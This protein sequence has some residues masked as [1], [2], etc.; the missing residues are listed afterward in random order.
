MTQ[1]GKKS[2]IRF[3]LIIFIGLTVFCLGQ[4]SW[5]II[6]TVSESSKHAEL[7]KSLYRATSGMDGIPETILKQIEDDKQGRIIMFV[8]ESS[9]FVLVILSGAFLIY[10][11]LRQSEALQRQQR[12]F[13]HAV[14]HEFRTPIT[15][16]KL[17]LETLESGNISSDKTRDI[18]PKM[19]DD[20]N[21]LETLID[22]VLQAGHFSRADYVLNL[23]ETDF[24]ED[25]REYIHSMESYITRFGGRIQTDIS[26]NIRV[27][28]DYNSFGRAINALIDNALKYSSK[29]GARISVSL[30]V[31][32]SRAVLKVSDSGNGIEPQELAKIFNRFYRVGDEN[33]R[34]VNG[35]GLGLFLVREIVEAHQGTIMA[36]SPGKNRGATFTI[37]LPLAGV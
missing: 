21:R 1:T 15:S 10:R 8:S 25:M 22:N 16:L 2:P 13:I 4:L 27:K 33:T 28:T 30:A 12:N 19:I 24:S 17:Y 36:T 32:G 34:T 9:F 20:T 18:Y 29:D 5:W 7:E 23:V 6:F 37:S 31:F 11:T 26:P 14:T 3:A 35:T